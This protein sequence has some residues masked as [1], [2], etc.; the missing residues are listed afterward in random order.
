VFIM[1][2]VQYLEALP[3]GRS[4]MDAHTV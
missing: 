1:S 4:N 2:K 3:W